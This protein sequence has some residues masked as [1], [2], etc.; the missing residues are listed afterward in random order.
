MGV[1][2]RLFLLG[3]EVAEVKRPQNDL[4]FGHLVEQAGEGDSKFLGHPEAEQH[5]VV[6]G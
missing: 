6:L 4:V 5:P 3:V 1:L 2:H